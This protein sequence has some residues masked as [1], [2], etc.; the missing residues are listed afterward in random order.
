[1]NKVGNHL[2]ACWNV[3]NDTLPVRR[4]ALHL[5]LSSLKKHALHLSRL[6]FATQGRTFL[7]NT[8]LL[9]VQ[10]AAYCNECMC[11]ATDLKKLKAMHRKD[12]RSHCSRANYIWGCTCHRPLYT[13]VL[14]PPEFTKES[15]WP[16][17][18][19]YLEFIE[20]HEVSSIEQIPHGPPKV[21]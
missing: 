9:T 15:L 18:H 6:P 20:Q 3:Q 19:F 5:C 14:I 17:F 10:G 12:C 2:R 11:W 4:Q 1:M 13:D 7:K 21:V 8:F 16:R